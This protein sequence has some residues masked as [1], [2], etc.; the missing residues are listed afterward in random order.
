MKLLKYLYAERNRKKKGWQNYYTY[1]IHLLTFV[2]VCQSLC[3]QNGS[4]YFMQRISIL[5][6][7]SLFS[8]KITHNFTHLLFKL[9]ILWVFVRF[10]H[11]S[12]YVYLN[13]ILILM[14]YSPYVYMRLFVCMLLRVRVY[15]HLFFIY[16]LLLLSYR[17]TRWFVEDR[18]RLNWC[19]VRNRYVFH[20]SLIRSANVAIGAIR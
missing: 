1:D 6:R 15:H 19:D 18:K 7:I 14:P 2:F 8:W 5:C 12:S 20:K 17:L 9:D 10:S 4:K 3:N 13:I 16:S 11:I